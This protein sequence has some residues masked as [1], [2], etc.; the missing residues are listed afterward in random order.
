MMGCRTESPSRK[1]YNTLAPVPLGCG[2]IQSASC[3][4]TWRRQ[5]TGGTRSPSFSIAPK[6]Y[7]QSLTRQPYSPLSP[8][9]Q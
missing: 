9:H 3:N 5:V 6:C 2:S 4:V 1:P 8:A 7:A